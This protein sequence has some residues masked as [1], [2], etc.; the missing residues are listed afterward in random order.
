MNEI[1][2]RRSVRTFSPQPVEPEKAEKLLRAAMQAPSARNQQPWEF[3]LV[4]EPALLAR[5]GGIHPFSAP[6]GQAPLVI[7]ALGNRDYMRSPAIWTHDMGAACENI[8][9]EAVSLGLGAV[10]MAVEP[11][12]VRVQALRDI[13]T[14]PEHVCPFAMIAAGYPAQPTPP[15]EDR[16]H[17]ERIHYN[18]Y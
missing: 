13:F 4:T 5:L 9:L 8:L 1:F 10:W 14:L 18:G 17:P 12:P 2:T 7:V 3:I 6:A 15:Q 11:D 16:F